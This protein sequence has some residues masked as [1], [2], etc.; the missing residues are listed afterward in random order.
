MMSM[1]GGWDGSGCLVAAE[2]AL[3]QINNRTDILADYELKMLWN[4]TQVS[5]INRLKNLC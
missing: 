1:S 2:L 4:D 3:E 5:L